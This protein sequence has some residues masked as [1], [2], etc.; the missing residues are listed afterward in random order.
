MRGYPNLNIN[1]TNTDLI[2]KLLFHGLRRITLKFTFTVLVQF[3][4]IPG[5]LVAID[6]RSYS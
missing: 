1:D 3:R 5:H 2:D 4:N 6:H